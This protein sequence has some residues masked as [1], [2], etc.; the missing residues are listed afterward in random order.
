M[1]TQAGIWAISNHSMND[2]NHGFR[3]RFSSKIAAGVFGFAAM[4]ALICGNGCAN[5]SVTLQSN[6]DVTAVR[7]VKRLYVLIQQGVLEKQ[8]MSKKPDEQLKSDVLAASLRN[9]LSNTPVQLE[10]SVVGPLALDESIYE[11]KI[12]GFYADAVLIIKVQNLV[13]DQFGG[14]PI[15]YY[16]AILYDE[17]THKYVW[18]AVINNSGDP[19]AMDQRMQK[20]AGAIV[21]QL[22]ADGFIE[23]R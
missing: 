8:P 14:S 16:D 22:R 19:G 17:I 7:P 12:Q 11:T 6:K 9:C 4:L 2:T 5:I 23:S 18:R 3:G 1:L 10:I 21:A 13:V 20:M 15:I